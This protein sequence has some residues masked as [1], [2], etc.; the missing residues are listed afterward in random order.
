[1]MKIYGLIGYPLT[2]SFS[3]PYFTEKFNIEGLYDC[4]YENFAIP[5]IEKITEVFDDSRICGLNVT[6]PYKEAVIPHLHKLSD[7]ALKIGAVNTIKKENDIWVGYNTDYYGF[8]RSWEILL[9]PSHSHALVLGTGGAAKAVWYVLEQRNMPYI[10][11]SRYAG[12]DTVAYESI[13][14]EILETHTVIINTTPL[15]MYPHIDDCPPLPYQHMSDRHYLYDLVY[16]PAKTLFLQ[17]GEDRGASI[18]SGLDMLHLQ[19]EKSWQIW[20]S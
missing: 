9:A 3:K 7:A 18:K 20:N 6:I 8:E 14:P 16:N 17:K 1:M 4:C 19:A 12:T 13:T 2:H 15:G 10:K 5:T 11:V